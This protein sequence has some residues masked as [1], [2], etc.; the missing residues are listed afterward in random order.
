M[1]SFSKLK[2]LFALLLG[3]GFSQIVFAQDKKADSGGVMLY[4]GP[5]VATGDFMTILKGQDMLE[6][7]DPTS[8]Y[9]LAAPPYNFYLNQEYSS[10][11]DMGI[12]NLSQ[13]V[14]TGFRPMIQSYIF[15]GRTV[16]DSE[17][18]KPT[19]PAPKR[20]LLYRKVYQENLF[21]IY[22]SASKFYATIDPLFNF[23]GSMDHSD[24][25]KKYV[26][27]T[28]GILIQGSVGDKFAFSSI[29]WEN[30]AS[31]PTYIQKFIN[32]NYVVPG[33]GRP[34]GFGA[35]SYDFS[36]TEAYLSFA[37]CSHFSFQLGYGKNFIGDGYRSL[38]LSDNSF[39][40]PYARFTTTFWHLQY[41]N[42]YT[43]F[44][45]PFSNYN[46]TVGNVEGLIQHKA[47]AFQYLSWNVCPKVEWGFS[48]V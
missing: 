15:P 37:P 44:Q 9:E 30:Q 17:R 25:N 28:R 46:L 5:Q 18:F 16:P 2:F 42:L 11:N 32:E 47:G 21:I 38:L 24:S 22:D 7:R 29:F 8:E 6:I 35:N 13:N 27:N 39:A 20:S 31:Y 43:I 36:M 4:S 19:P 40:Y 26:Q 14:H 45:D 48:R 10:Y 12:Y 41:T 23:Q 34:K 3:L 1:A 33:N